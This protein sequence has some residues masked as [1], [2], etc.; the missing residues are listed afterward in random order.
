[1]DML[2]KN[3]MAPLSDEVMEAVAGG[4]VLAD[5]IRKL[6]GMEPLAP[7]EKLVCTEE[8]KHRIAQLLPNLSTERLIAQTLPM[9][10][11]THDSSPK[12]F[13]L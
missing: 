1:M 6:L 13:N 2:N 12:V 4:G 5:L 8:D 3:G 7:G 11:D 9:T 10:N